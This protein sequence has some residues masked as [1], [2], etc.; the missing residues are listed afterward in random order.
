MPIAGKMKGLLG[1]SE[2]VICVAHTH[3]D[4]VIPAQSL[5]PASTMLF[6]VVRTL[7]TFQK[8]TK[9]QSLKANHGFHKDRANTQ[10]HS[11]CRTSTHA[12]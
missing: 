1:Q 8:Y 4:I 11:K 12:D 9:Y 2:N 5:K 7:S 6:E 10:A 3:S